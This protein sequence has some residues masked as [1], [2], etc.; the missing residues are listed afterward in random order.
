MSHPIIR[1]ADSN[2]AELIAD[3]S[4]KT[5]LETFA[6]RNT[7]ANMDKFM[8]EQFTRENL[9]KEVGAD[10]NIFLIA[11]LDGDVVGYAR[12]RESDNPALLNNLPSIEI[13]RIYSVQSKIGKG[14]GSALMQ[15]CIEVATLHSKAAIWLGVWEENKHAISFY[16][17][18]GFEIFDE[19]EFVLGDDVQKDWLMRK[20]L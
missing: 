17:R 13:A 16:Q 7:Q 6:E 14:I 1:V 10:G 3:L 15:K 9:I 11:E 19:H 5:F 18:W 20:M 12:L 2:D 4:R 8:N